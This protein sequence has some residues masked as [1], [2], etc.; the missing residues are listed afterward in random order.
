MLY[1]KRRKNLGGGRRKRSN[2]K[3]NRSNRFRK[4]IMKG[5]VDYSDFAA[6]EKN[7][8]YGL[9]KWIVD[10]TDRSNSAQPALRIMDEINQKIRTQTKIDIPGAQAIITKYILEHATE[11]THL[12]AIKVMLPSY[13]PPLEG[14]YT[15]DTISSNLVKAYNEA[16]GNPFIWWNNA[17]ELQQ[18]I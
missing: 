16:Q 1:S 12:S 8:F 5:G 3:L 9:F 14:V 11:K 7:N 13:E 10:D 15:A 17:T 2:R 4:S 6:L 18:Y